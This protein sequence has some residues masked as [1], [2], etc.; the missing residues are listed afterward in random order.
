MILTK[1]QPSQI[2]SQFFRFSSL[3]L[4]FAY[5]LI[6]RNYLIHMIWCLCD[7]SPILFLSYEG[8]TYYG[9][10]Y[11]VLGCFLWSFREGTPLVRKVLTLGSHM[12]WK[13]QNRLRIV[14]APGKIRLLNKITSY[15]TN[16]L[17][18][19]I[20]EKNLLHKFSKF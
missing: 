11:S 17:K 19:W 3:K 8:V 5:W 13:F 16:F 7:S 4:N 14:P 12:F 20:P 10:G 1:N 18:N 2:E 9:N 15:E 6:D